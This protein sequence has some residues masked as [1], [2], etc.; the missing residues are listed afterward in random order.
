MTK[1]FQYWVRENSYKLS[2][3][4]QKEI[5]E[6]IRASFRQRVSQLATI[7]LTSTVQDD[8][9]GDGSKQSKSVKKITS[10]AL[11]LDPFAPSSSQNSTRLHASNDLSLL[12]PGQTSESTPLSAQIRTADDL[13]LLGPG[14]MPQLIDP[15]TGFKKPTANPRPFSNT[16]SHDQ[17]PGI[18]QDISL[19]SVPCGVLSSSSQKFDPTS[20]GDKENLSDSRSASSY[21]QRKQLLGE[22]SRT[23]KLSARAVPQLEIV[24][25]LGHN[26][27]ASVLSL[28]T[29][30]VR[31]QEY[32]QITLTDGNYDARQ[33]RL[34]KDK[35]G[36]RQRRSYREPARNT[37]GFESNDTLPTRGWKTSYKVSSGKKPSLRTSAYAKDKSSPYIDHDSTSA[38]DGEEVLA[39]WLSLDPKATNPYQTTEK[40]NGFSEN[41]FNSLNTSD[42][43]SVGKSPEITSSATGL[44]DVP[45]G[46]SSTSYQKNNAS[47]IISSR[48]ASVDTGDM[49]YC[50][51]D[52][53]NLTSNVSESL[54][55]TKTIRGTKE[56]GKP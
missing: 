54:V 2:N 29:S 47:E 35:L 20:F 44:G 48:N 51:N 27:N 49:A 6:F 37:S 46:L 18:S 16:D 43:I 1:D 30:S 23:S 12:G 10:E 55:T 25:D 9:V 33:S 45:C 38:E 19:A 42:D 40:L 8:D 41:S 39:T 28:G 53:P 50:S 24:G 11:S 5:K 7:D 17:S 15:A 34:S 21:A 32:Q 22:R 26:T 56:S 13:S 31:Q 4:Q 3:E 36:K 14:Q 52:Q